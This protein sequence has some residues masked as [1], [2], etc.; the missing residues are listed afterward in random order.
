MCL[1]SN[2]YPRA[3][4][5]YKTF[6]L[7]TR[8]NIRLCCTW[9]SFVLTH[10]HIWYCLCSWNPNLNYV[11]H[12]N[13]DIYRIHLDTVLHNNSFILYQYIN[14]AKNCWLQLL[15]P[16]RTVSDTF[17]EIIII[18][19]RGEYIIYT[20]IHC[21]VDSIEWD[22]IYDCTDPPPLNALQK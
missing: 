9:F 15:P 10:L 1:F 20:F 2:V 19:F 14:D 7:L 8:S 13:R 17:M 3:Y 16:N 5:S 6:M 21:T 12:N 22:T 4:S 11:R 18:M